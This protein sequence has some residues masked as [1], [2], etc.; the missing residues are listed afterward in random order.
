MSVRRR[1]LAKRLRPGT[2]LRPKQ[3]AKQQEEQTIKC[4]AELLA[5]FSKTLEV[6]ND[7]EWSIPEKVI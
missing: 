3:P 6:N 7:W 2:S 4:N 1:A 5:S